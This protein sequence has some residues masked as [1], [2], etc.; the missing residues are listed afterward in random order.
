MDYRIFFLGSDEH[1]TGVSV[2][3]GVSDTEAIQAARKALVGH[4]AVEVWENARMVG[5]LDAAD[6]AVPLTD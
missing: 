4:P 1:F 6:M 3:T 5:R 2:V